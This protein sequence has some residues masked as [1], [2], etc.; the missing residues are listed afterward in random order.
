[1]AT[2]LDV[3]W[4]LEFARDG[5]LFLTEKV[6]RIRVIGADGRLDPVPWNPSSES[7]HGARRV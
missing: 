1:M 3:V 7:I 2:T 4:S 5:R 6:G